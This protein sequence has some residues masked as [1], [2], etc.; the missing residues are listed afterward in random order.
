MDYKICYHVW[1]MPVNRNQKWISNFIIHE[2]SQPIK[3]AFELKNML[4]N[5]FAG[6]QP[7]KII[8]RLVTEY[9]PQKAHNLESELVTDNYN[10][11]DNANFLR[12]TIK[13]GQLKF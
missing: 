7:C 5:A 12:G 1:R 6:W 10:Q 8:I 13:D 4:K 9:I 2:H 3:N 11:V